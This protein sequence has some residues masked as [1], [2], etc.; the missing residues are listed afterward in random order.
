MVA[1]AGRPHS[2][3]PLPPVPASISWRTPMQG[4]DPPLKADEELPEWLWQLAEPEKTLNELRRMKSESMTPEL[5]S[6]VCAGRWLS[7]RVPAQR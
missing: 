5:V 4:Q 7:T 3:L 2:T 6:R 1:V